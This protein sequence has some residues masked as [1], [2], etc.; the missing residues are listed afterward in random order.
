MLDDL[1]ACWDW[2]W[3]LL[4]EMGWWLGEANGWTYW[5]VFFLFDY[6]VEGMIIVS[7]YCFIDLFTI[8]ELFSNLDLIWPIK[9]GASF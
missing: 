9:P 1:V 5:F 2:T 3:K 7:W 8:D 6:D 4:N